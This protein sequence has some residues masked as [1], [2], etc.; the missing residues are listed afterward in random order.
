MSK[1]TDDLYQQIETELDFCD[2]VTNP[3][4]CSQLGNPENKAA[5]IKTIAETCISGQ[6]SISQAI[7]QTERFYSPNN[8]D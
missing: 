3:I 8:I 1:L 7:A 6:L 4:I 2:S 5:L